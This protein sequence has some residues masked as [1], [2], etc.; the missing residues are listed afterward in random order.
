M[1]PKVDMFLYWRESPS[2]PHPVLGF[3]SVATITR[4]EEG[5]EAATH[6]V[7]HGLTA[8][9]RQYPMLNRKLSG[10]MRVSRGIVT[11][12]SEA[13]TYRSGRGRLFG[14]PSRRCW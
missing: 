8:P 5:N 11:N 13:G 14:R 9:N 12:E 3:W 2:G 7:T 10:E 1:P 6:F 4:G